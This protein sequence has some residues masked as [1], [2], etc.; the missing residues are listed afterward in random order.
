MAN[1][2]RARRGKFDPR[3][4]EFLLAYYGAA[5]T[6]KGNAERSALAAGYPAS[7]GRHQAGRIIKRFGDASASV[8]LNAAGVNKPYLAMRIRHVLEN[9]GDKEILAAARLAYALLGESTDERGGG[10]TVNSTAPVMVVVGASRER[11]AALRNA[12]PQ[13]S[14]DELERLENERV[15]AKLARLRGGETFVKRPHTKAEPNFV[16]ELPPM[17]GSRPAIEVLNEQVSVSDVESGAD[18][19]GDEAPS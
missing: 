1:L 2:A 12:T 3:E 16:E 8:S 10:V 18:V 15:D 6:T 19:G 4:L 7:V 17:P 14:R 11:I 5:S 9:G 13:L